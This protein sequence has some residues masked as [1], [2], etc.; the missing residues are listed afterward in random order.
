MKEKIKNLMPYI[1]T[2]SAVF[3]FFV[4]SL[5]FY[6]CKTSTK[7]RIFIFPSVE[8]GNYVVEKRKLDKNPVQ[9]D[10]NLYIDEILLGSCIERTK[11]LFSQGTKVENCFVRNN[12][13]YLNLSDDLLSVENNSIVIS[14]GIDLLKK[15]IQK[16]FKKI[17]KIELFIGGK[18][19]YSL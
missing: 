12:V 19:A 18:Y 3:L 16:N 14:E 6:L 11:M 13:L 8:F 2:F 9:G 10:I 7:T 5:I 4:I 17:E 1:I 15:N